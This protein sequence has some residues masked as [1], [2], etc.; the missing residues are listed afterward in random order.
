MKYVLRRQPGSGRS[1]REPSRGQLFIITR[2]IFLVNRY[3][4][5]FRALPGTFG[6][7][8]HGPLFLPPAAL[9]KPDALLDVLVHRFLQLRDVRELPLGPPK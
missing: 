6:S 8:S 4:A 3:L 9:V 1:R 5:Q 2:K 7:A